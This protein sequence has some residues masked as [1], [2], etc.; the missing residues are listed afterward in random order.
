MET[1]NPLCDP[2]FF[3]GSLQQLEKDFNLV[4]LGLEGLSHLA[5]QEQ[6]ITPDYIDS[7]QNYA[8]DF[9]DVIYQLNRRFPEMLAAARAAGCTKEGAA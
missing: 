1:T 9:Q 3:E 2:G 8:C 7:L 6:D 5:E 4:I